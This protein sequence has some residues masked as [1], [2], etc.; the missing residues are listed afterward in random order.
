MLWVGFIA[1]Y[2]LVFNGDTFQLGK[3]DVAQERTESDYSSTF[4][5][6]RS[7]V[8]DVPSTGSILYSSVL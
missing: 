8:L 7:L 6:L 5:N 1:T 3:E 2:L 4:P